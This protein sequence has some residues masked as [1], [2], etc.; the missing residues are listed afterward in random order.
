M[1]KRI[2]SS[3]RNAAI[4]RHSSL[5]MHALVLDELLDFRNV[6]IDGFAPQQVAVVDIPQG[7]DGDLAVDELG[8]AGQG[9]VRNAGLFADF[10]DAPHLIPRGRRHRQQKLLDSVGLHQLGQI[11]NFS[12]NG[13]AVDGTPDL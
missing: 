4:W 5:P 1:S 10:D 12:Q 6:Q 11:V 13:H 3:G 8:N 7:L 9:L 2:S